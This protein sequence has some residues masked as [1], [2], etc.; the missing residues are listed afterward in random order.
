MGRDTRPQL[1][2]VAA[3]VVWL[4][5]QSRFGR[6]CYSVAIPIWVGSGGTARRWPVTDRAKL[7][8]SREGIPSGRFWVTSSLR[9]LILPV[10]ERQEK[11]LLG[12]FR[13]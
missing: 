10:S 2:R 3:R 7:P 6:V 11:L 12:R 8:V 4:L 9:S 1:G 5:V 13:D